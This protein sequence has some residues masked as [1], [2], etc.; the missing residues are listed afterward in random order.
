MMRGLGGAGLGW[1][2]LC[3]MARLAGLLGKDSWCLLLDRN[4]PLHSERRTEWPFLLPCRIS[5]QVRA[6]GMAVPV[7]PTLGPLL[8]TVARMIEEVGGEWVDR[9]QSEGAK[10]PRS[11]KLVRPLRDQRTGT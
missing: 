3:C 9:E 10:G 1:E 5:L 6:L 7:Y 2:L 8:N 11:L 4:L